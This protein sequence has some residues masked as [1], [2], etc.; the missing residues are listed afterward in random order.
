MAAVL[1]PFDSMNA[2]VS[3]PTNAALAD[4]ERDVLQLV[5]ALTLKEAARRRGTSRNTVKNQLAIIRHKLGAASTREAVG[6]AINLK[7]I[8]APGYRGPAQYQF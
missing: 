3:V 1:V 2:L 4:G 7:L 5:A 6:I 8:E